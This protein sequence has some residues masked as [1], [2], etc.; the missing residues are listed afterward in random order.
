M[1]V[2]SVVSVATFKSTSVST[3]FFGTTRAASHRP[4]S[5]DHR[6]TYVAPSGRRG[7]LA[8]FR[9]RAPAGM[10]PGGSG[11]RGRGGF[12]FPA[13]DLWRAIAARA[14]SVRDMGLSKKGVGFRGLED[15]VTHAAEP[16]HERPVLGQKVRHVGLS[17]R[18]G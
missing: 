3:G 4:R 10:T 18:T 14:A 1:T 15:G 9:S 11:G 13:W 7:F 16:E 8:N 17:L 2:A 6:E 12:G 5:A